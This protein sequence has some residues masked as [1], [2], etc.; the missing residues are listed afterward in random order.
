MAPF[1]SSIPYWNWF[2][3]WW[4]NTLLRIPKRS[5]L[6]LGCIGCI[7]N[8]ECNVPRRQS[9]PGVLAWG[10]Q[11]ILTSIFCSFICMALGALPIFMSQLKP[12]WP[13]NIERLLGQDST[14]SSGKDKVQCAHCSAALQVPAGYSGKIQ[15]PSCQKEMRV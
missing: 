7:W 15:C 11:M 12:G 2:P 5:L 3:R 10:D 8:V 6:D 9:E 13:A 4:S 14:T 1:N